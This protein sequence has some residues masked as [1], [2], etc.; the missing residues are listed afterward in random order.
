MLP[1]A[2]GRD[3]RDGGINRDGK[4]G[5]HEK[6]EPVVEDIQDVLLLSAPDAFADQSRTF[7]LRPLAP[8]PYCEGKRI[9]IGEVEFRGVR[10][11]RDPI[12]LPETEAALDPTRNP[13]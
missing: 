11:Q 4:F 13:M 1:P 10:H 7:H 5:P 12:S 2:I 6:A 8:D 9:A 3:V